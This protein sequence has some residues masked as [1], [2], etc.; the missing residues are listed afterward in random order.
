MNNFKRVAIAVGIAGGITTLL[1][2]AS[3]LPHGPRSIT[4]VTNVHGIPYELVDQE[5][6]V[7]QSLAHFDVRLR[8]PVAFKRL[9]LSFSFK[10]EK[11]RT[12][13]VGVRENDFWLSY[14]P[15]VFYDAQATTDQTS[16]RQTIS[17]PLTD[18]LQDA[19]RSIDVLF[20][21]NNQTEASLSNETQD[22]T[23]WYL[24]DIQTDVVYDW[25]TVA[26]IKDYLRSIVKRERPL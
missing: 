7:T 15:T 3:L 14:Q 1:W 25:P 17:I 9:N 24:S 20:I 11:V 12:V 6:V 10:P 18:K 22:S 5:I 26:A 2:G 4:E 19:D 21:A 16:S 8:E 23:L 13:A